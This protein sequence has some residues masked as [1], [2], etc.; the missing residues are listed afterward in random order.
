MKYLFS[1]ANIY[2]WQFL[3]WRS[4]SLLLE[5]NAHRLV[6]IGLME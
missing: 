1:C 5:G 4:Y 3:L 2:S 6:S